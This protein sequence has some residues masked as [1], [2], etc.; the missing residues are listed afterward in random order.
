MHDDVK[1]FYS[2]GEITAQEFVS[3]REELIRL[4][5]STIRDEGYVPL[6]DMTPQ[7]TRQYNL[8]KELFEFELSVYG[9]FIGKEESWQIAGLMDG[10]RVPLSTRPT[11]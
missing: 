3:A 5:E 1:R 7:F 4:I 6:L 11:K 10:K 2:Y 8:E 9:V